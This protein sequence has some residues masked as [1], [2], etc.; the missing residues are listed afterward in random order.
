MK[1]MT[2]INGF[3]ALNFALAL[4]WAAI[5]GAFTGPNLLI[6]FV[7]GMLVLRMLQQALGSK[8]YLEQVG[9]LVNF[10]LFFL[11]ELLVSSLQVAWEVI[12]PNSRI[13]PG[14]IAI[15][16]DDDMTP[17]QI[18]LLAN[19]ITLTPGTL[20]IDV[21]PDNRYLYIHGMYIKDIE[22][23]KQSI[24]DDFIARVKKVLPQ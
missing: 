4:A 11:K 12:T 21:S 2:S 16:L 1:P 22:A 19:T 13:T 24:R 7:M 10:I 20:S 14:V 15:E 3:F 8:A 9:I 18:T 5:S 23:F 17:A 6:G